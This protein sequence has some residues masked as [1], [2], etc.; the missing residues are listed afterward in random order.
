MEYSDKIIE[1]DANAITNAIDEIIND[2]IHKN[3]NWNLA[4][5]NKF[6]LRQDLINYTARL[7]KEILKVRL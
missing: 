2:N 6:K 5:M 1:N 3:V 7:L 4:I